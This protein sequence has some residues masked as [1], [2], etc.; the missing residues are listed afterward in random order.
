MIV[1]SD[2][3]LQHAEPAYASRPLLAMGEGWYAVA[4]GGDSVVTVHS[5]LGDSSVITFPRSRRPIGA[6]ERAAYVRWH[7]DL[8][9]LRAS[10]PQR[11]MMESA[12][13][14]MIERTNN[15]I[16]ERTDFPLFAPEI[17]GM[18]GTDRCLFLAG[19]DPEWEYRGEASTWL[20]MRVNPLSVLGRIA[21]PESGVRVR[22]VSGRAVFGT[23]VTEDGVSELLRFPQGVEGC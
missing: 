4:N 9:Y 19:F 10:Q 12:P 3:F 22:A 1:R 23:R 14:E 11:E 17:A 16:L 8:L 15:A 6:G 21:I 13:R 7:Y 18:F 2:R 5:A 20:V